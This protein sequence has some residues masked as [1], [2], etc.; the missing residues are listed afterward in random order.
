MERLAREFIA[1][2][3]AHG[4]RPNVDNG[5]LGIELSVNEP[6]A[7]PEPCQSADNSHTLGIDSVPYIALMQSREG[8]DALME[9]LKAQS[10]D[11]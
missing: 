4:H 5:H 11:V 7:T 6:T 9:A 1:K 8:I 10:S 3:R 2:L